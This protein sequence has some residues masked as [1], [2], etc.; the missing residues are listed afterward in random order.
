MAPDGKL[1]QGY[2]ANSY[3]A[4]GKPTFDDSL[5]TSLTDA[6][7]MKPIN[8]NMNSAAAGLPSGIKLQSYAIGSD[9][10]VTGT[11]DDGSKYAIGKIAI[12]NVQN[13]QAC[14]SPA[15]PST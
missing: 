3:D 13:P 15:A 4:S 5:M 7:V 12:A 8:L 9:G 14:R 2:A 6:S 1:V 10:V 11:Y